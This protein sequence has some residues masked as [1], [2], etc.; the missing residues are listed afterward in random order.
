MALHRRNL[1]TLGL[2]AL[3]ATLVRPVATAAAA[4]AIAPAKGGRARACILLFMHGGMSQ[5]DTF[6]PKPGRP[7]GGEFSPIRTSLTG[8]RVSEHLPGLAKRLNKTTLIRSL[9]SREGNHTRARH[10]MHTGYAPQ[11]GARPPALGSWVAESRQSG[12]LPG[13]VAID[14]PGQGPGFL[15]ASRAPFVVRN[16]ARPV[17][18]MTPSRPISTDRQRN[19]TEMW[20]A[21]QSDFGRAHPS[22]Q[23]EGH[24]DVVEQAL[25]MMS[26]SA[27]AAFDLTREPQRVH[28]RYGESRFA[29]GCLMARRLVEV[30]VPFVEVGLQGWDTH[31]NNFERVRY[32]SGE[33][34]RGMSALLDDLEG[35]GL[36]DETLVL[37]VGDFG[38]TPRI[39]GRGGR[40]HFPAAASML[41]A[42]GG[43]Q[44]GQVIGAT[45]AD[46]YEITEQPVSVPDLMR[47]AAVAMG[48]D[49]NET[50]MTAA[51]RPLSMVDGGR[52]IDG[53]L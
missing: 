24:D 38:R 34:D 3:T 39:N 10:L 49:P 4:R 44:T 13:Y 27:T 18:N 36:L 26:S 25:A 16:A 12:D 11:G 30:G 43:T 37:C 47:T 31:D 9:T 45:D 51:G 29:Q 6:D 28:D 1:L 2:G 40:D 50:R 46:G 35:S 52:V 15:G 22:T 48:L 8:V 7:T 33:L 53:V 21:L 41:M 19:R 5:I 14:A 32:L 42:G 23:V 20:R 17:R